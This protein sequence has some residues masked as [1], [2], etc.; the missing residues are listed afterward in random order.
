V[1]VTSDG[2]LNLPRLQ[3][4]VAYIIEK[5]PEPQPIFALIQ[6]LG[7]VGDAEMFKTYN[8]GTG[9]CVIVAPADVERVRTIAGAHG[10]ESLVLGYCEADVRRRVRVVPR[11]LV[12][13]NKEF[14]ADT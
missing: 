10:V 13:E 1:H 11:G 2:F 9:F 3:S 7:G 8:M 14:R 4:P 6:E 5:V 12:G